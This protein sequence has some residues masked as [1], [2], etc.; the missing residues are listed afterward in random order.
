[1]DLRGERGDLDLDDP[2]ADPGVAG[3]VVNSPSGEESSCCG[4]ERTTGGVGSVGFCWI[5][6]GCATTVMASEDTDCP[7]DPASSLFDADGR[8][9]EAIGA[10]SSIS[11]PMVRED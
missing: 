8:R 10:N 5:E 7:D 9:D 6:V 4:A 3:G 2:D 1:M 11:V